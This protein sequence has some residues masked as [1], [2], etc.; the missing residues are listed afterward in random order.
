V[1]K[2]RKIF[3]FFFFFWFLFFLLC[4][5][6]AAQFKKTAVQLK[7]HMWWKN[8]KCWIILIV[9]LLVI[10]F[11][12]SLVI[13]KGNFKTCGGKK[14][15]SPSPSS[16]PSPHPS[17][18]PTPHGNPPTSTPPPT[19]QPPVHPPV[20]VMTPHE[21][22]QQE[23]PHEV[24]HAIQEPHEAPHAVLPVP[25]EE[26]PHEVIAPHEATT[27]HEVVGPHEATAP[28][29]V[30]EPHSIVVPPVDATPPVPVVAP[31]ASPPQQGPPATT[32][33]ATIIAHENNV[34][35]SGNKTC[36][37]CEQLA[38]S[39]GT[40]PNN[41]VSLLKFDLSTLPGDAEI[42]SAAL[43]LYISAQG[44]ATPQIHVHQASGKWRESSTGIGKSPLVGDTPIDGDP[45]Y[46]MQWYPTI[47]WPVRGGKNGVDLFTIATATN[48]PNDPIDNQASASFLNLVKSW[49][50]NP[51]MNYGLSVSVR[52][53]S[54]GSTFL[55]SRNSPN[56]AVRPSITI[57]YKT[58]ATSPPTSI[59]Q[60]KVH[61]WGAR[62]RNP[63]SV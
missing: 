52:T 11:I 48:N 4:F 63:R 53:G 62:S 46:E 15:S 12:I 55:G 34:L 36:G 60:Q 61:A 29:A 18:S 37:A 40:S 49:K 22:P 57:S 19:A 45:T 23:T 32:V 47:Y 44:S 24:P 3:G 58:T 13:C 27:P 59:V 2:K 21:P 41:V 17:P 33:T 56:A 9:V 14:N 51:T 20:P 54:V 39:T 1:N 7:R 10:G 31:I 5:E 35:I 25:H 38:V 30:E 42:I 6:S 8:A 43:N 16:H 28:H 26:A 50:T